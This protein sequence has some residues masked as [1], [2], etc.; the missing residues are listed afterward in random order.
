M[1]RVEVAPHYRQC[2]ATWTSVVPLLEVATLAQKRG[3]MSDPAAE[4]VVTLR[5]VFHA[6]A[7]IAP[8]VRQTP[9]ERSA[10][11][12]AELGLD[13]WLKLET[14]Q[15]TGSFKFRGALNRLLTLTEVE[16]AAGII[17]CSAGNHGLGVAMAAEL[18][19]VRATIV[20][21]ENVSGAK[22]AGLRRERV[23]TIVTGADYDSAEAY[24]RELATASG[25]TF[26]SPYNDPAVIAGAGTVALETLLH[27][28][29]CGTLVV[30]VSGGG[31]AAG[32]GLVAKT[33]A[34]SIRVIGVQAAASPA[35]HAAVRAGRLVL[36]PE[37]PTL[38]D[39]LAGNVET[40][41]ITFP[42]VRDF[43]DDLLLV[44][45]ASIAGAIRAFVD[46]Q[47]VIV[48]GA[49]AVGLAAARAGLLAEMPGPIVLVVSGRN[50]ATEVLVSLLAPVESGR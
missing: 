43:L 39:G 21:P 50:V 41:S 19:G 38:A 45:E 37:E 24:A 13:L 2:C 49:G 33:I 40:G 34:P 3:S 20:V 10:A 8:W 11:F 47:H 27:L 28:P 23:E 9:L 29:S 12:S 36:V 18:T 5:D 25:R 42:L 1:S 32:V 15:H 44:S 22:L 14:A 35:M 6:A 46:L 30:P 26:V 31:L 7:R 4:R 17:T 48:E 16:R